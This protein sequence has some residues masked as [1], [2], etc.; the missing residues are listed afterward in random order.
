MNFMETK[1]LKTEFIYNTKLALKKSFEGNSYEMT[2]FE[3]NDSFESTGETLFTEK[4]IRSSF[5]N[6]VDLTRSMIE[7]RQKTKKSDFD[8]NFKLSTDMEENKFVRKKRVK[9][10]Y[11]NIEEL[12]KTQPVLK[13]NN[14]FYI[15]DLIEIVRIFFDNFEFKDKSLKLRKEDMNKFFNY[16]VFIEDKVDNCVNEILYELYYLK[17][18]DDS[19]RFTNI[20]NLLKKLLKQLDFFET[21]IFVNNTFIFGEHHHVIDIILFVSLARM[22]IY[23]FDETI[24]DCCLPETTK[25]FL[26][27]VDLEGIKQFYGEFNLCI[28]NYI[29]FYENLANQDTTHIRINEKKFTQDFCL[30]ELYIC[31]E[32]LIE[33]K[34]REMPEWKDQNG[35]YY[36]LGNPSNLKKLFRGKSNEI[37]ESCSK[38]TD[39]DLLKTKIEDTL[40]KNLRAEE[41][42]VWTFDYITDQEDWEDEQNQT[43][44]EQLTEFY[45]EMQEQFDKTEI[46]GISYMLIYSNC[47]IDNHEENMG[48]DYEICPEHD[49]RVFIHKNMKGFVVV[50][51]NEPH[52]FLNEYESLDQINL[53][54]QKDEEAI[55]TLK[56]FIHFENS[57]SFE[58]IHSESLSRW[59]K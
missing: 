52:Q 24:R 6:S 17:D 55:Q 7:S 54:Q 3:R 59:S 1:D 39:I 46:E 5:G 44:N 26:S 49:P 51:G 31:F 33:L 18:E 56:D 30:K 28:K 27:L 10:P 23:F 9:Q 20:E 4:S 25:W 40:L 12:K 8:E 36:V 53:V 22:Y 48:F 16:M 42:S 34:K 58:R 50:K 35:D 19:I 21:F 57:F 15:T 37:Y 29:L 11:M 2:D 43:Q 13:D 14:S 32:R 38:I 45:Q 47:E 41:Y